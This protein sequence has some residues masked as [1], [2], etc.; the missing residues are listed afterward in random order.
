[1][2]FA[3]IKGANGRRHE[4]D[5]RD[6]PVKVELRSS[7]DVVEIYVELDSGNYRVGQRPFI[8]LNIPR[9]LFSEAMA[10]NARRSRLK[11]ME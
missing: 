9:H 4:A 2:T 3:I 10:E 6:E 11:P 5:F 8:Q 7:E 1:M